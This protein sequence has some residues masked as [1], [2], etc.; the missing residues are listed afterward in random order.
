MT[1]I[2]I[3]INLPDFRSFLD[4]PARFSHDTDSHLGMFL[5]YFLPKTLSYY[6]KSF[7][8]NDFSQIF[9]FI[10]SNSTGNFPYMTPIR[11]WMTLIAMHRCR[12]S[13]YSFQFLHVFLN[14][15]LRSS[16][17]DTDSHLGFVYFHSHIMTYMV[18]L[19]QPNTCLIVFLCYFTLL[20]RIYTVTPFCIWMF[21]DEYR[22]HNNSQTN[23]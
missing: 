3:W 7:D 2:C 16:S 5:R 4:N 21:A 19:V 6:P 23:D 12:N 14:N 18:F 22:S 17:C 9:L 1:P 8:F 13:R 20:L 15:L 10:F 11:I